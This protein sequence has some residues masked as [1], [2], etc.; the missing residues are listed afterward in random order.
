M[1]EAIF[2][3]VEDLWA[4]AFGRPA[5][6]KFNLALFRLGAHGLGLLNNR[7]LVL[8][9]EAWLIR[10]V[11]HDREAPI[12]F[13]VGA[14][15]GRWS[16]RV[17][18]CNPRSRIFAFE[19]HRLS[20]ARLV[21]CVPGVRTFNV[22]VGERREQLPLHDYADRPGSSHASLVD[23][24]IE[25]LNK[26][27]AMIQ[28]VEV[29]PLDEIAGDAGVKKIDLLKIDVEGMEL[30]V[31]RGARRLLAEDAVKCIQFEFNEMNVLSRSLF[32]DFH[33]LLAPRFRLYRLLPHGWLPLDDYIPWL[34]EQ[35]VYQNIV[36]VLKD[37]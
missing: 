25:R 37:S 14:H 2:R 5:L 34:H 31:L 28:H 26:A 10:H 13:D 21:E 9:G 27:E 33:A 1:L 36:A 3:R 6:R 30:A 29:L 8:S 18:R 7:S 16:E 12:V 19:P 15:E 11:L 24:V 4:W 32:A 35:F 17:L 20:Y 23:G 22:A